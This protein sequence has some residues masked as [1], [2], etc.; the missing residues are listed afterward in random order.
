M[1]EFDGCGGQCYDGASNMVHVGCRKRV[2]T[3]LARKEKRAI[4]T[5]YGHALNLAVGDSMKRS[6]VCKDVLDT[7]F[8]CIKVEK[9]TDE[10]AHWVFKECALPDVE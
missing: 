2:T 6:K 1:H 4:L 5:C 3:Q 10:R 9:L 7:A 8:D